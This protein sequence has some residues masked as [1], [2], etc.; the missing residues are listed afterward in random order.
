VRN[1][2]EKKKR[3]KH[4]EAKETLL[5]WQES[6]DA[7]MDMGGWE[8]TKSHRGLNSEKEARHHRCE[9]KVKFGSG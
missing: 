4:N 1:P 2:I 8:D 3:G 9:A 7:K 6:K 5:A